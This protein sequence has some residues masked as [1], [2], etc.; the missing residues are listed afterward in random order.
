[1][2]LVVVVVVV[3]VVVLVVVIVVVVVVVVELVVARWPGREAAAA[4]L[5]QPALALALLP[6]DV[7][8]IHK[9]PIGCVG[10]PVLELLGR[11][12]VADLVGVGGGP[13]QGGQ[14]QHHHG[15]GGSI[16]GQHAGAQAP[17]ARTDKVGLDQKFFF[18]KSLIFI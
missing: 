12:A 10:D 15:G 11:V 3:V 7:C 17:G 8:G 9:E 6:G 2:S 18:F 13:V 1:M 14:Q 16:L 5:P 4:A